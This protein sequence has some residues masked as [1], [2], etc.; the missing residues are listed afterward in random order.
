MLKSLR[1]LLDKDKLGESK[2]TLTKGFTF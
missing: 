2:I 1:S